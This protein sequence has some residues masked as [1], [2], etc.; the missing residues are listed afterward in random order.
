MAVRIRPSLLDAVAGAIQGACIGDALSMPAHWFYNPDDIARAF[1]GRLVDFRA[2]PVRH[3]SSIMSLSNTGGAGRGGRDGSIIGDV[4][5]HGK[6][7]FWGVPYMHY[8][9][10]MSAGDNTLNALCARVLIRSIIECGGHYSPA[11]ALKAYTTFMTTPG[12]HND[13][14]AES[15]HRIF[16]ANY[17]A[18]R[19]PSDCSGETWL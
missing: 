1:G 15:F 18:G 10:G 2:P 12:S 19:P 13:T 8:H 11:S 3:P 14:Y 17:A 6:K 16:F 4:I 5:N 9:Q 7:K